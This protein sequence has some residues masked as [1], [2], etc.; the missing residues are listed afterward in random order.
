MDRIEKRVAELGLT[1]PPAP[2]PAGKYEPVVRRMGMLYVSGQLPQRDGKIVHSGK[3]GDTIQIA[4]GK[5]ASA[6]ALLGAL[7]A[8]RSHSGSLTIIKEIIQLRGFVNC[9]PHFTAHSAVID[10]ASHLLLAIFGDAGRHARAAVG[11]ASL[12]ANSCVEIELVCSC[13]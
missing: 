12:P 2:K 8:I 1:I 9:A 11:V 10:G 4:D 3:L 7:A 13:Q 5:E 6:Q